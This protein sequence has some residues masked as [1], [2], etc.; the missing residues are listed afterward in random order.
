MLIAT[1]TFL[2]QDTHV[3]SNV[4]L[5]GYTCNVDSSVDFHVKGYTNA[6]LIPVSTF[7][8]QDTLAILM[9]CS[10]DFPVPGYTG[11]VDS[12]ANVPSPV[13]G[14]YKIDYIKS[15]KCP[16]EAAMFYNEQMT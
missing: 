9:A 12:S 4:D 11:N 10:V 3:D 8:F 7:P 14:L 6:V 5:K 2:Y 15:C 1:L 16:M 13:H